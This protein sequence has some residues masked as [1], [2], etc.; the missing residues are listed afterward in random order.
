MTNIIRCLS[1]QVTLW[2]IHGMTPQHLRQQQH[3]FKRTRKCFH[4]PF[5]IDYLRVC[6]R[7]LQLLVV[8]S[9]CNDHAE[10]CNFCFQVL[11][12]FSKQPLVNHAPFTTL[13]IHT[14]AHTHIHTHTH[15]YICCL[16][17][18]AHAIWHWSANYMRLHVY[19]NP[20]T[21]CCVCM[22][23]ISTSQHRMKIL[24]PG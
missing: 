8:A 2:T 3:Q 4:V 1:G 15:S 21:A 20:E 24:Q 10:R 14:H 6:Y 9:T 11:W 13:Y 18:L 17:V 19:R 16:H 23:K 5:E 22:D 7:A 12:A